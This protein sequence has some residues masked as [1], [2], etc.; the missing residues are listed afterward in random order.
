[1]LKKVGEAVAVAYILGA[2]VLAPVFA[3]KVHMDKRY[4]ESLER[5]ERY[6]RERHAYFFT[7]ANVRG[8]LD[9]CQTESGEVDVVF[10]EDCESAR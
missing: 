5:V 10:K 6:E 7:G 2:C 8:L 1:M 9:I 3:L 4:I